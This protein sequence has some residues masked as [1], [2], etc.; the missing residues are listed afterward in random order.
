[1]DKKTPDRSDQSFQPTQTNVGDEPTPVTSIIK[2]D[3]GGTQ[4]SNYA[5]LKRAA[6]DDISPPAK[7]RRFERRLLVKRIKEADEFGILYDYL[8]DGEKYN[9]APIRAI[10]NV[11]ELDALKLAEDGFDV[12]DGALY[13]KVV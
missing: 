8:W 2:T 13:F 11:G 10:F 3:Q 5:T 7:E 4:S 12:K 9:A 6:G 1:M